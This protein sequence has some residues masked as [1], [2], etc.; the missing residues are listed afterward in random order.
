MRSVT[1]R[2]MGVLLGLFLWCA[3]AVAQ[4]ATRE[5][6]LEEVVVTAPP[7]SSPVTPIT[8]RFGT[9]YNVV[10]EDQITEQSSLDLPSTLRD[11]PGVMFQ[12]EN[13]FG[14]Q[15]GPNIYIRGRGANHPNSD[16]IVQFDGV[17]RY[18]ALFGQTMG[19]DIAVSTI[20][21]IEVY[22]SPQPA[23]FGSG[24]ALLNVLPKFQTTEGQEAGINTSAGSFGTV[25]QSVFAGIKRD[26]YDAYVSQSW[27]S[28]DGHVDHSR[29]QQQNYYA[30]LGYQITSQWNIRFLANYVD[31]QTVAPMPNVTPTA[32]NGVS[33]PGAERY[34]TTSTFMTLTLN[35]QSEQAS[36]F[37]KAYW[38]ET[39]F[40]ILQ[41]LTNGQP[42]AGGTG[43]LW[44][45]QEIQLYGV[46]GKEA[47][48]L[49]PGG[50]ILAG[51]DVDMTTL[52]N[53]QRTY[54][55]QA[56]P[57]INGGL[58]AEVWDFPDVTLVSPYLAVSQLVG[59]ADG[60]HLTPSAAFRYFVHNQFQDAPSYQGGLVTGYKQT[61]LHINYTRGVNYPS[62]VAVMNMMLTSAPVADPS[63]YWRSL[64]PELV[65]HY[66]VGLTHS[67]PQLASLSATAFYD[68]GKDRLEVYMF[69]PIPTVWNDSIGR[70]EIRGLEFTG[71][72]T[73]VRSLELFAGATLLD[74]KATGSNGISQDCLPYTPGLQLQAGFTW[75]FLE[76]FRLYGDVEYLHDVYEGIDSRVETFN[77]SPLPDGARLND[78][79]L[80]NA[81]LSYRFAYAPW[82]V[83]NSEVFVAVNNI[84]NQK[85]EY[86]KGY[87]MP[88]TTVFAGVSLKFH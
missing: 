18:G 47:F 6:G 41:E 4:E 83:S 25:D 55:G 7:E 5:Q 12:S 87:P 65:D 36:G 82:R 64:K 21:G 49:W 29:A 61:D 84:L 70:Y 26:G 67:W 52:K 48:H 76:H 22:K 40:D 43:G 28:T 37:L 34:D 51:T 88:G 57:G 62:P 39:D 79:T 2:T 53:T 68:R 60:F 78:I 11:V 74:A 17:P 63:Q 45:R 1:L 15:T 58:A 32:T 75:N 42:Y 66:E 59:A 14:G 54:T 10:T 24:Y 71:K 8:T 46:R 73:P 30:N 50:E 19:D 3:S 56:V 35:N 9:Q 86:A 31:S 81:R 80:V 23:Q 33:Y 44:S 72:A 16:F 20:G 77:F 85:Y 27:T 38:N 69:G 13:L